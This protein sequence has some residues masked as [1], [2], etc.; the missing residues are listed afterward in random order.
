MLMVR[1]VTSALVQKGSQVHLFVFN[2]AFTLSDKKR[3]LPTLSKG[4]SSHCYILHMLC[5]DIDG[6]RFFRSI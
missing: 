5:I 4:F 3:C 6:T 2:S 1:T